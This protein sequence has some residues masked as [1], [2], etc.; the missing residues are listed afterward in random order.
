MRTLLYTLFI[1]F[2]ASILF[3]QAPQQFNYQ[4][5]ARDGGTIVTGAISLQL[6]L[7]Q[8]T[9]DGTVVF[10][11]RH[12]TTTNAAGV[13][14][15]LV[16]QGTPLI[17]TIASID[18][19]DGP[20]FLRTEIDPTGG[21]TFTDLGTTPMTSVPYA[22]MAGSAL[23]DAVDDA[24]ADPTNEIQALAFDG[25]S[26]TLSISAGNAVVLPVG[27]DADADPTNEIQTSRR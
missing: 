6:T 7:H 4:G 26:K 9:P 12:A 20:F 10:R 24:D 21:L 22:L 16:G 18:W 19:S 17:G 1:L 23:N 3:A 25:P 5:V 2:F 27:D 14:N 11:E 8:G 15:V 13:F